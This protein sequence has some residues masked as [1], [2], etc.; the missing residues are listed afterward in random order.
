M[1]PDEGDIGTGP[2][3]I[4]RKVVNAVI[5]D[6]QPTPTVDSIMKLGTLGTSNIMFDQYR[7]KFGGLWVGGNLDLFQDR[8]CFSPNALNAAIQI[9]HLSRAIMLSTVTNVSWRFGVVT[10][11]I[12]V[13]HSGGCFTFRCYGSKVLAATIQTTV[14]TITAKD[15][16]KLA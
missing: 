12:D 6:A 3:L 9:G 16:E 13:T 7:K 8:L 15:Q 14:T 5:A 11:I 1:F 4:V 10:G 2:K